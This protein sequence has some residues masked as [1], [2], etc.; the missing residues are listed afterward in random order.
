MAS[1]VPSRCQSPGCS[2]NKITRK[3]GFLGRAPGAEE[4][5]GQLE[6]ASLETAEFTC[7]FKWLPQAPN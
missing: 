4:E 6:R 7:E 5:S 1:E 3:H 2:A